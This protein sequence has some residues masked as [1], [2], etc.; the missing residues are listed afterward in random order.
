MRHYK[1][2]GSQRG[3]DGAQPAGRPEALPDERR[4]A[5]GVRGPARHAG[6]RTLLQPGGGHRAGHGHPLPRHVHRNR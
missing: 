1:R 4:G 3:S 6:R 5:A 2:R